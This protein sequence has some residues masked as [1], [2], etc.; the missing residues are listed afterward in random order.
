MKTTCISTVVGGGYLWVTAH[1]WVHYE[2]YGGLERVFT[3]AK[4]R[5]RIGVYGVFSDGNH[6]KP[7]GTVKVSF[8]ILDERSMKFTF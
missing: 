2:V 5:L 6:I 4:R 1:D 7:K 3:F 8:A